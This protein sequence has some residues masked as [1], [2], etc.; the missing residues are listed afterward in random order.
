MEEEGLRHKPIYHAHS[1]QLKSLRVYQCKKKKKKKNPR[2]RSDICHST[3]CQ[4]TESV[5]C[6]HPETTCDAPIATLVVSFVFEYK[7]VAR[8]ILEKIN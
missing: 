2:G 1:H 3:R 8:W 5:S 6:W 7:R 4:E